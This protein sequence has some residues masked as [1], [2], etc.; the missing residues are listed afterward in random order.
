[1]TTLEQISDLYE[2][3]QFMGDEELTTALEF[4]AK[5]ILKP[6][7]PQQVVMVE[8]VRMQAIA[9]KMSLKATYMANVDRSNKAQKNM[10]YTAAEQLN[11][12]CQTLKY[13]V[14]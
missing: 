5:V 9:A 2:I 6:D 13:Y 14:K 3:S 4:V 1:M 10:Y 11:L 12:L 8:L 7:I